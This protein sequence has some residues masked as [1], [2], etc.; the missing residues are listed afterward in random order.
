MSTTPQ[1]TLSSPKWSPRLKRIVVLVVIGIV[2]FA[3][4]QLGNAWIP[5]TIAV[6]LAYLLMPIVNQLERVLLFVP[7]KEIRRTL[8]VLLTFALLI[9]ALIAFGL[10]IVPPMTN[11]LQEFI[12]DIPDL[13]EETR[14]SLE[15]RLSEPINLGAVTIEPW[16]A[17]EDA[18]SNDTGDTTNASET[19]RNAI[20]FLIAPAANL[21]GSVFSVLAGIFITIALLFYAMKDG[22][23]LVESVENFVP[24]NYQG[25]IRFI[26]TELGK[27]WNAYLRGQVILGLT[28]GVVTYAGATIVGLPQPLVLGLIAALLEFIPNIG[29]TLAA[30]PA[31]L[32][33]LVTPSSTISGLDG[34]ILFALIVI[35]M[36]MGLQTL[37]GLIL[38]PRVMGYSLHLHPFVI[39]VALTFGAQFAGILGVILAAPITATLR[40]IGIYLW[41]KLFDLDPFGFDAKVDFEPVMQSGP[42]LVKSGPPALNAPHTEPDDISEGEI[43]LE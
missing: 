23:D 5:V 7:V 18:L 8:A 42:P 33:A 3:A 32:I 22:P 14:A 9:G 15:E 37:E 12:D 43:V 41:A 39:L 27:I 17:I 28:M 29:P 34:G 38:V 25:D 21:V 13:I 40:L 1:S 31:V 16:Q 2:L 36:Y 6:V 20:T 24:P 35:A 4:V 11:Q 10:L 26:R 30:M 19:V